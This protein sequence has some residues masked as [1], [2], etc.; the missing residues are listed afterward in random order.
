MNDL[1]QVVINY[2]NKVTIPTAASEF[3]VPVGLVSQVVSGAKKASLAMY[4]VVQ[5]KDLAVASEPAEAPFVEPTYPQ[6]SG[7]KLA[8]L[9]TTNREYKYTTLKSLMG[10][11][12]KQN[13]EF[14]SIYSNFLVRGRNILAD[15]FLRSGCEYA[16]L[17]DDDMVF[18]HGDAKWFKAATGLHMMPDN[19]AGL[20]TINVLYSRKK[21]LIG[22]V[23]FGRTPNGRGMFHE[24]ITESLI[25]SEVHNGPRDI[26][27]PTNWV[28][29]GCM[30][31]HRSVF[32]DIIKTQP[33]I[34]LEQNIAT[35]LGYRYGFFDPIHGQMGEDVSFCMRAKKAGHQPYI[36][37]AVYPGHVGDNTFTY[38]N[39]RPNHN[40]PQTSHLPA[41][42]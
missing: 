26:V 38:M 11:Y 29:T 5:S 9:S 42:I 22:G 7:K 10:L 21:T 28:A 41:R 14:F 30:L 18:P 36:D 12:D 17:V 27:R 2:I 39:T 33:E 40:Q 32:E 4:A 35:E 19:F 24:A 25:N 37:L 8:I 1:N 31:V 3:E 15:M 20:N 23:Y 13:M 16:F 34:A 6:W